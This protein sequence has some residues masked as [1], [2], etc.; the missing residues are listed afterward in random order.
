MAPS[1]RNCASELYL[2]G[3]GLITVK[4][5]LG[6]NSPLSYSNQNPRSS[7]PDNNRIAPKNSLKQLFFIKPIWCLIMIEMSL[8]KPND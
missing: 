6:F 4:R 8:F 7:G 1:G 2:N 3:R 5:Q